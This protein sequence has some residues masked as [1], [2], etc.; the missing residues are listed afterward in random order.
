MYS[1]ENKHHPITNYTDIRVQEETLEKGFRGQP[2]HVASR[3]TDSEV[4]ITD[5]ARAVGLSERAHS[6]RIGSINR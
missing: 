3:E 4:D 5:T 1:A 2:R 6:V